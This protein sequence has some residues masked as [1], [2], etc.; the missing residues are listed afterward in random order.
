MVGQVIAI[1]AKWWQLDYASTGSDILVVWIAD[2]PA[3]SSGERQQRSNFGNPNIG[4]R[5]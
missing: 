2:F 3:A 4:R 5:C 1:G